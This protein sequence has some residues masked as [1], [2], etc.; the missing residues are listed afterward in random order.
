MEFADLVLPCADLDDLRGRYRSGW[1]NERETEEMHRRL[2]QANTALKLAALPETLPCRDKEK[3]QIRNV[4]D[5]FFKQS[6]P[7]MLWT[8][9]ILSLQEQVAVCMFVECQELERQ[10]QQWRS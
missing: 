4:L 1:E 10:P 5:D 9:Q 3:D 8:L 2:T 6:K 7:L